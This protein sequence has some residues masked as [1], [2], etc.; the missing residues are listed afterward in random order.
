MK[1]RNKTAH[2]FTKSCVI[3]HA[4]GVH[5]VTQH[6]IE[7]EETHNIFSPQFKPG[8]LPEF[9]ARLCQRQ[10]AISVLIIAECGNILNKL[11]MSLSITSNILSI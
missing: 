9:I 4:F 7:C 1:R 10:K 5:N 6:F 3:L 11:E 8:S 2:V